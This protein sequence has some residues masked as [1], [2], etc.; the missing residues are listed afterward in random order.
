MVEEGVIWSVAPK[1]RIQVFSRAKSEACKL[2]EVEVI[3][4]KAKLEVLAL[5]PLQQFPTNSLISLF[6]PSLAPLIQLGL[7]LYPL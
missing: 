7:E 2:N 5:A 3:P 4:M 6:L 1:S